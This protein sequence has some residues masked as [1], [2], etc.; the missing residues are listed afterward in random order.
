MVTTERMTAAQAMSFSTYSVANASHVKHSLACGCEPYVD[1]FTYNRWQAQGFQV[2]RGEKAVKIPVVKVVATENKETGDQET[3][4]LLGTGA[5]FCRHQVKATNGH[6]PAKPSP[7]LPTPTQ[8]VAA[9]P[10]FVTQIMETWK[11]V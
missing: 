4:K 7:V 1:V 3:R 2:Q 9:P 11:E 10:S 8:P 6:V 5:V